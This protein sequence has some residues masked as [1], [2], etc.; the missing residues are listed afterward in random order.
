MVSSGFAPGPM[1][2]RPCALE[3]AKASSGPDMIRMGAEMTNGAV[4]HGK[5]ARKR[6]RELALNGARVGV[7]FVINT[8]TS[9]SEIV[10]EIKV[11]KLFELFILRCQ[12]ER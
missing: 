11:F 8:I 3:T 4:I 12:R 6:F 9:T 10:K 5:R 1:N 7:I 2:P